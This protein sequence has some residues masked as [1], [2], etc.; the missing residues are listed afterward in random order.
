MTS[1]RRPFLSACRTPTKTIYQLLSKKTHPTFLGI[2]NARKFSKI[3]PRFIPK[4]AIV[5]ETEKMRAN[6]VDVV[7]F[8]L[9]SV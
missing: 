7:E 3:Q 1:Y 2:S 4:C 5:Y 6:H 9:D 8:V